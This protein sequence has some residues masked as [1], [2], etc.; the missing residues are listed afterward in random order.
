[1]PR[2]VQTLNN[3]NNNV[4]AVPVTIVLA[5]CWFRQFIQSYHYWAPALFMP[6]FRSISNLTFPA[7][8]IF[9]ILFPLT[10][11]SAA[12]FNAIS[13][14]MEEKAVLKIRHCTFCCS[15]WNRFIH[16]AFSKIIKIEHTSTI[17]NWLDKQWHQNSPIGAT[18]TPM[19]ELRTR[20]DKQF[21]R[22]AQNYPK[23][24]RFPIFID[25]A[26]RLQ[27]VVQICQFKLVFNQVKH[28]ACMIQDSRRFFSPIKFVLVQKY[29]W[30]FSEYK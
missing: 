10:E 9:T 26:L 16:F 14:K 29:E 13:E 2:T 4:R 28:T 18:M 1:M 17:L 20:W 15:L 11:N 24:F 7:E 5:T 8:R 6:K 22:R 30:L 12:N 23:P 19:D 25:G 21:C 27:S 3:K